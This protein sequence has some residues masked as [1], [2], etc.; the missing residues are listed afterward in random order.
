[1]KTIPIHPTPAMV[2]AAEEAYMPF[3]DMELAIRLAVLAAPQP[4]P[5]VTALVEALEGV[6][7][8]VHQSDGAS[9]YRL[10][11][12]AKWGEFEE[13]AAAEEALALYR[14]QKGDT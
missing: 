8:I 5:D 1:M 4:T 6:L 7:S 3:G 12:T 11:G 13:V 10:S 9:G 14:Q 2:Q